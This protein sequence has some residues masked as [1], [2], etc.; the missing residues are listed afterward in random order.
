MKIHW[1]RSERPVK[2]VSLRA[3]TVPIYW[4]T[5]KRLLARLSRKYGLILCPFH[6]SIFAVSMHVVVCIRFVKF[7]SGHISYSCIFVVPSCFFFLKFFRV[8]SHVL[9]IPF[10]LPSTGPTTSAQSQEKCSTHTEPTGTPCNGWNTELQRI[11]MYTES[12]CGV[13]HTKPIARGPY[14]REIILHG[15]RW[16]FRG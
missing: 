10:G 5:G 15:N 3:R 12:V 14:Y 7:N 13:R 6:M 11:P 9:L 1:Y 16:Q 4:Y 8:K 2:V